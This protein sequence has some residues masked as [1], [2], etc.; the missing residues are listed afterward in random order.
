MFLSLIL[1]QQSQSQKPTMLY[2]AIIFLSL[3][4]LTKAG[5]PLSLIDDSVL[6]DVFHLASV[7]ATEKVLK[8]E[9]LDKARWSDLRYN[10][11]S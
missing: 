2:L 9:L 6:E 4:P 7:S 1:S 11:L 8:V 10:Y 3:Y 5:R